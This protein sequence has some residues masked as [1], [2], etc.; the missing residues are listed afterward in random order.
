[1]APEVQN[2]ISTANVGDVIGLYMH[3]IRVRN[4]ATVI[5]RHTAVWK[6]RMCKQRGP[7]ADEVVRLLTDSDEQTRSERTRLSTPTSVWQARVK[8][9]TGYVQV[10]DKNIT[11]LVESVP[12]QS[13][14]SVHRKI[15]SPEYMLKS[16]GSL[17]VVM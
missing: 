11:A 6:K 13:I 14:V 9:L 17:Q 12:D 10:L 1:M 2:V 4:D 15:T 8:A 3:L 7:F 16:R 5:L